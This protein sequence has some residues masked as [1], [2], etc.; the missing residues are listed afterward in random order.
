MGG[1]TH[2]QMNIVPAEKIPM[3]VVCLK[4]RIRL[5]AHITMLKKGARVV[6]F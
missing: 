3:M 6:S 4:S 1:R 2:K 5:P